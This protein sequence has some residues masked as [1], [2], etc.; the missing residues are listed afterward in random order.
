[1]KIEKS[2]RV[3][4]RT[5][6]FSFQKQ[7]KPSTDKNSTRYADEIAKITEEVPYI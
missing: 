3:T 4:D 6:I 7:I 1:V 5:R 2:R